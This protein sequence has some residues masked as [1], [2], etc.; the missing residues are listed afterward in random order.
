MKRVSRLEPSIDEYRERAD[1]VERRIAEIDDTPT[2]W[3]LNRGADIH[4]RLDISEGWQRREDWGVWSKGPLSKIRFRVWRRFIKPTCIGIR[5]VI[6]GR[7][8]GDNVS[9]SV[10]INGKT[11]PNQVL[12]GKHPGLELPIDC[13]LPYEM[14]DITLRHHAPISPAQLDGRKDSRIIAFGLIKFGYVFA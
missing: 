9:T 11:Y 3:P 8:F 12:N 5:V 10:E 6:R 2:L 7:Y 1:Q 4:P 13:L 14:I